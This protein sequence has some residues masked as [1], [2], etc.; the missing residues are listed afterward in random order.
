MDDGMAR[1][2]ARVGM[3]LPPQYL[4]F[5]PPPEILWDFIVAPSVDQLCLAALAFTKG[6]SLMN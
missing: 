3:S 5:R 2:Y 1:T 6:S 4:L